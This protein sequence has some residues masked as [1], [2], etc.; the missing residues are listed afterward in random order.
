MSPRPYHRRDPAVEPAPRSA[1]AANRDRAVGLRDDLPA[2]A[3]PFPSWI[4][5][6]DPGNPPPQER[7]PPK[8][9]VAAGCPAGGAVHPTL[10]ENISCVK[11]KPKRRR[12]GPGAAFPVGNSDA[13]GGLGDP[14]PSATLDI[15]SRRPY[16]R[17]RA[18]VKPPPCRQ[19]PVSQPPAAPSSP[20]VP[21]TPRPRCHPLAALSA[22]GAPRRCGRPRRRSPSPACPRRGS[23]A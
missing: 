11:V 8:P 5:S 18:A 14:H 2:G 22:C 9:A 3:A 13:A 4:R 15:M 10:A 7:D 23:G 21:S 19:A 16:H 1:R 6:T 12:R 17:D 20:A